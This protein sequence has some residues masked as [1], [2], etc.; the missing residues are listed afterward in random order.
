MIDEPINALGHIDS[1][2]P[3][4]FDVREEPWLT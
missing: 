2:L 1:R 3:D 4:A